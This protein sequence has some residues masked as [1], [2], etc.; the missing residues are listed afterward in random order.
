MPFLPHFCSKIF[1]LNFSKQAIKMQDHL[2][3]TLPSFSNELVKY[4]QTNAAI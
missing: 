4:I 3:K 2:K 1:K